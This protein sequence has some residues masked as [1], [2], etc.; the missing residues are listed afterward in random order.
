VRTDADVAAALD[1]LVSYV[2]RYVVLS[3]AQLVAVALWVFHTHAIESAESTAYLSA[4]SALPRSGKSLLLEVLELLVR[5]PLPTANISDAALFRSIEKLRPTLLFDE[6]DAI[7][8]PKA[9]DR[10]DLRGMLNAGYRRGAVAHRMGGAN[11]T[12]LQAFEVFCAKAFAGIGELPA[13]IRDRTIRIRLE[14]RIREEPI[15]RFRRR[16][17]GPAAEPIRDSIVALAE[18]HAA[19]LADARPQLPDELDDRAQDVWEPLLAIAELAGEEWA[20]R[21]RAAA[22]ALS[23]E[24]EREDDSP[25]VLLL[26]DLHTVFTHNG[27]ADRYKTADLIA[28][29]ALIEE[30][31][32]GDWYGKPISPQALGK[33]LRPYRIKTMPVWIDGT[34]VRGYKAEQF[35]ETWLRVLGVRGVRGVRTGSSTEAVSNAPDGANTD[36]AISDWLAGPEW[37]ARDDIW[38]SL[39]DEPPAFPGEVIDLRASA[40]HA[41]VVTAGGEP[42]Q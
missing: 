14:R 15:E 37:L 24:A 22:R 34:T 13:T 25:S 17:A 7:F 11:K 19:W 9:R 3:I 31:P 35:A 12:E 21:A 10:E 2:R 23:G 32:W 8:G 36:R 20:K 6:I 42:S 16:D 18:Q 26:R 30:S 41:A 40:H 39:A 27:T 28:Q 4:T 38:R 5:Q 1:A 29:L 33:L